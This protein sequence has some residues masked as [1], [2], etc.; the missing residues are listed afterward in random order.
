MTSPR[1]SVSTGDGRGAGVAIMLA[2]AA[3][4][5]VLAPL[6]LD[7]VVAL[8]RGIFAPDVASDY[9]KGVL[10]AIVLAG[11]ILC[12]PVSR[13]ERRALLWLW[14]VRCVVTLGFMLL[15]EW[16][17]ASLDAYGYF[18]ASEL[19]EYDWSRVRLGQ[20]TPLTESLAWLH[21]R[22]LVASYHALKVSWSMIGLVAVF[23]LYRAA[24]A[25]F[26][27]RRLSVLIGLSCFPS[28]LFWSSTLGKDPIVLLGIG[29]FAYGVTLWLRTSRLTSLGWSAFGL[30]IAVGE[31]L[32]LGPILL[33]PLVIVALTK[34]RGLWRKLSVV[35]LAAVA[36]VALLAPIREYLA[37]EALSDSLQVLA[38]SSQ[39]WA[40]GGSAQLL[41]TDL[42]NPVALLAFIPRGM[43]AALFRPLPGEIMN[44]F[45]ILA[46]LENLVVLGL[47]AT[48]VR[49]AHWRQLADPVLVWAIGF[50]IVWAVVYGPI[51]YQNLGTAVRFRLQVLPIM[52]LVLTY[53]A[54]HRDR[55]AIASR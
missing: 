32:W 10:W 31:R 29:L 13:A 55:T 19:P 1:H 8:G 39:S 21:A 2:A 36:F 35:V 48:A 23:V 52:L 5:A 28:I 43:V 17:Y 47:L 54:L 33:S 22:G 34:V 53:V 27:E 44:P 9:V 11:S 49:R 40:E 15:Y 20:G 42:S 45:G 7:G 24:S 37:V 16:N 6:F 3:L 25:A 14:L 51:S 41:S 12:W 50:V 26:G 46:G 38:A 18:H 30:L 4:A